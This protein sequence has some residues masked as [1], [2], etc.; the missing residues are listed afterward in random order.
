MNFGSRL[1]QVHL[2]EKTIAISQL[3]ACYSMRTAIGSFELEVL[4]EQGEGDKVSHQSLKKVTFA[5]NDQL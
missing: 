4:R 5:L 3:K 1:Q 2:L